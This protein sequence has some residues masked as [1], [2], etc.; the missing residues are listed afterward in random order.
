MSSP[1]IS[2]NFLKDAAGN[3]T[4]FRQGGIPEEE[5]YGFLKRIRG[6]YEATQRPV[7]PEAWEAVVNHFGFQQ[8]E[9][10]TAQG[11]TPTPPAPEIK[12]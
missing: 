12:P 9:H 6:V 10:Q 4:L 5:I 1:E 8:F 7:D 2:G 3:V 11:Q